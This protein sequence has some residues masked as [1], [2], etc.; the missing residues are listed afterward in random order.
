MPS[1]L[2]PIVSSVVGAWVVVVEDWGAVVVV[3]LDR[4][5]DLT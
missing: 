4:P 1:E 5:C 2:S 3:L